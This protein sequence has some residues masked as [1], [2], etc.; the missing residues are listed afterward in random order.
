MAKGERPLVESELK[1]T[2][3]PAAELIA[4]DRFA[5]RLRGFGPLGILAIPVILAGN[6]I[7]APL[8]AILVL[9]WAWRS[10]T[11]WSEI[12]YSRPRSWTLTAVVG[13]AAGCAF[14]FLM[15]IVVM[16]LLGASPINEAYHYLA[17]NR[18]AIPGMIF[19]LIIVAGF[20]EKTLFRGYMFERFGKLFGSSTGA[21]ISIVLLTSVLFGLAHF[22]DQ[23]LAGAEQA[24]IFG[25]VLGTIFAFTR[26][27]WMP[28]FA[29]AAFDLTAYALIYWNLESRV[30]HLL[31]K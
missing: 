20:G 22:P 15:K 26:R 25:V 7:V 31:F 3:E 2:N 18:A 4:N 21:R 16:P 10:R 8:S 24:A 12:G 30:A 6:L 29:H 11:L 1:P 23:G 5:A 27:I 13:I 19:T 14:K 28:M 17:G 9:V